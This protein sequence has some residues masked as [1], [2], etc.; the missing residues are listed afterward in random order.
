MKED[1]SIIYVNFSPYENVGR[2]LDYLLENFNNVFLFS[3]D[4][5]KLGKVSKS[6]L[7]KVFVNGKLIEEKRLYQ[8]PTPQLLL[9]LFLPI[10]SFL[11]FLQLLLFV[12][13]LKKKHGEIETYFTV[14]AF[15]IWVGN[16][17][18]KIKLVNKTVFWVWD[19]YPPYHNNKIVVFMRWIYWQ[20]DKKSNSSNKVVFLNK[21]LENLRKNI[22]VLPKSINHIIV[23]IGTDPI[24]SL[25]KK[26]RKKITLA[27]IGVLKK[28]QGLDII[29]NQ[30]EFLTEKF[31]GIKLKVI[32][33][34]PDEFYF[35]KRAKKS[36]IPTTFYGLLSEQDMHQSKKILAIL[37]SCDI[38]I[39]LYVPEE[40][41]VSYY[42]D[43]SKVKKYLS[44]ALPVITTDVYEFSQEIENN[45]AG[46]IINYYDPNGLIN[47]I[48]KIS[49]DYNSYR[50][51]ALELAK[52]YSYRN[53]YKKLFF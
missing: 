40:S 46:E 42:G 43:P 13:L 5:Y 21:R 32:G 19:Y 14:N 50:K 25:N 34:G 4:F 53:I 44:S 35:K 22:G 24:S 20:F 6:N 51:S 33:A 38:G 26:I 15:T 8:L 36:V 10:R 11:I 47:A 16:I 2:I 49:E 27:F 29:F 28:S 45:K 48:K 18:R 1:K 9:F 37:A 7:L 52:Q 39:A 23:P 30:A 3:F 31:P 17:L 12:F 41:N